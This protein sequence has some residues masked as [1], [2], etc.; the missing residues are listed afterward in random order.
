MSREA[1]L[2]K[3]L[4]QLTDSLVG[5]FDLVDL[6]TLVSDRCVE[7]LDVSAAGLMLASPGGELRRVALSSEAMRVLE[8]FEEESEEGPC[9][10]CYRTG[11]AV[12]NVDLSPGQWAMD[13]V[14]PLGHWR[15]GS[16]RSTPCRCGCGTPRSER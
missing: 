4:V 2:T 12:I 6:L 11:K 9:P 8:V 7:I 16:A 14:L 10:D 5:D 1:L 3:T 15:S 13:S